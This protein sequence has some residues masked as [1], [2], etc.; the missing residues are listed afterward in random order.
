MNYIKKNYATGFS[1]FCLGEAVFTAATNEPPLAIASVFFMHDHPGYQLLTVPSR[2]L[3]MR[4]HPCK[5]DC[6]PDTQP[7]GIAKRLPPVNQPD[8]TVLFLFFLKR[9]EEESPCEKS[10]SFF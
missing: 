5:L 6:V 8:I 7:V 3:F 9:K 10:E 2:F 1:L 4:F